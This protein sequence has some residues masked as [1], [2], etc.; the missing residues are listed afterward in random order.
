MN[1][2]HMKNEII[3]LEMHQA[4]FEK[5]DTIYVYIH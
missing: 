3:H 5:M 2:Y 1:L 4:F